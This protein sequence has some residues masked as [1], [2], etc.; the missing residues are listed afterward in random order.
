MITSTL[1]TASE[2]GPSRRRAAQPAQDEEEHAEPRGVEGGDDLT[3]RRV[4]R[5]RS[6]SARPQRTHSSRTAMMSGPKENAK[7]GRG[8]A[9][10]GG[11]PRHQADADAGGDRQHAAEADQDH[12]AIVA[13]SRWPAPCGRSAPCRTRRAT[14]A[15][16]G[17]SSPGAA[18]RVDR[19]STRASRTTSSMRIDTGP[20]SRLQT[21]TGPASPRRR[22]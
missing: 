19:R 17:T 13:Q 1:T 18:R 20:A 21:G 8:C 11:L 6:P 14:S 16:T 12:R 5:A 10:S 3:K 15:T 7:S 22:R 9:G 2:R 4:I